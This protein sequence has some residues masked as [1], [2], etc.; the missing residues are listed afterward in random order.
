[1]TLENKLYTFVFRCLGYD[2]IEKKIPKKELST[3]SE[4]DQNFLK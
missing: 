4:D 1:M 3:I 2:S